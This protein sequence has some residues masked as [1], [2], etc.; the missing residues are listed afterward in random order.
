MLR[1][2]EVLR[3]SVVLGSAALL[4]ACA[5]QAPSASPQTAPT[6]VQAKPTAAAAS[7]PTIAS[8]SAPPIAPTVAPTIAPTT[9]PKPAAGGGT[10]TPIWSA[11]LTNVNPFRTSKALGAWTCKPCARAS[12]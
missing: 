11:T 1:R 10:L 5:P 6:G 8:T 3:L 4:E 2:R 12:G 7:A 9:A